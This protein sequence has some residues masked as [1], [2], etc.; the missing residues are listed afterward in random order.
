MTKSFI[1]LGGGGVYVCHVV[2][3]SALIYKD[4]SAI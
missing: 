4:E 1:C 2:Q 3:T